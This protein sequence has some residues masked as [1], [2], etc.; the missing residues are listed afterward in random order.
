MICFRL[1]FSYGIVVIKIASVHVKQAF[2]GVL[3][4]WVSSHD[5]RVISAA[6]VVGIVIIII[7]IIVLLLRV[8]VR[9]FVV[10]R[11]FLELR[12]WKFYLRF[13]WLSWLDFF[14]IICRCLFIDLVQIL[15]F[16]L[17]L[18]L[19]LWREL[20]LYWLRRLVLLII[21]SFIGWPSDLRLRIAIRVIDFAVPFR[22]R[23]SW[24]CWRSTSTFGTIC[25]RFGRFWRCLS[26]KTRASWRLLLPI[27]WIL[28]CWFQ[29]ILFPWRD[30]EVICSLCFLGIFFIL[31]LWGGTLL[32]RLLLLLC[33]NL[34]LNTKNLIWCLITNSHY[35][36]VRFLLWL[37]LQ[38]CQLLCLIFGS[39]LYA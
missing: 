4:C 38:L 29:N 37:S 13:F 25:S 7:I 21:I 39:G 6:K 22:Q 15:I 23:S 1:L 5:W 24:L 12:I 11:S 9:R 20:W 33:Q 36:W 30:L 8:L 34:C 3:R 19:L 18:W 14:N 2:T 26:S 35:C 27:R 10:F 28:S 32:L 31:F 17:G 16:F